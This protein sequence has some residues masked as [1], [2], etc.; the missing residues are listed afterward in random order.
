MAIPAVNDF[1]KITTF[2][3][4]DDLGYFTVKTDT[5]N[6]IAAGKCTGAVSPITDWRLLP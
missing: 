3:K 6:L 4:I 5:E 1:E 2:I